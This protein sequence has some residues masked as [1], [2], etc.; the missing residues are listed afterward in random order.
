M[1]RIGAPVSASRQPE[2]VKSGSATRTGIEASLFISITI[3]WMEAH[4]L[5]IKK[6]QAIDKPAITVKRGVSRR[7]KKN[8]P[9][10]MGVNIFIQLWTLKKSKIQTAK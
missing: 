1:I 9:M 4:S 8:T 3:V 5:S 2:K 10:I 7:A 6:K